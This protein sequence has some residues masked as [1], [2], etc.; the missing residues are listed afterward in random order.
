M[1][2]EAGEIPSPVTW[3]ARMAAWCCSTCAKTRSTCGRSR[4]RSTPCPKKSSS[5]RST[6]RRLPQ[7]TST[8]SP[9]R[10]MMKQK[11]APCTCHAC[12]PDRT[13]G[14]DPVQGC[15]LPPRA[16]RT[17]THTTA[18]HQRVWISHYLLSGGPRLAERLA[19]ARK[20]PVPRAAC[21]P[22]M[23][24]LFVS[25]VVTSTHSDPRGELGSRHGR[26]V[27]YLSCILW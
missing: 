20:D 18:R 1:R 10:L 21:T 12:T 11:L 4:S 15:A 16:L 13:H 6:S 3:S 22:V 7:R 17:H 26:R 2:G 5:S 8:A 27:R 25:C 19:T 14:Y 23:C 9:F 24:W